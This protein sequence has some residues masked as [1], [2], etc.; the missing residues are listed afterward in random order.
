MSHKTNCRGPK[1]D[2]ADQP[3]KMLPFHN[4]LF[5]WLLCFIG[6]MVYY[7]CNHN[8]LNINTIRVV[9]TAHMY[10]VILFQRLHATIQ[11]LHH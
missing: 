3:Q 4:V 11:T 5:E 2:T 6:E 8:D 7:Y 10:L 1:L 9:I